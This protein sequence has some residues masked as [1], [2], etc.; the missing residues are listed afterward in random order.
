MKI[1]E[2]LENYNDYLDQ[3]MVLDGW[4]K[5]S[6]VSLFFGFSQLTDGSG[7]D[8]IQVVYEGDIENF[9]EISKYPLYSSIRVEGQ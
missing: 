9:K 4:I 8:G 6:C 1:R 3:T 5:S 7:F 2:V